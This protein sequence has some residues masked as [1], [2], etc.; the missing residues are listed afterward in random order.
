MAHH[1]SVSIRKGV[2]SIDFE[3]CLLKLAIKIHGFLRIQVPCTLSTQ[4]KSIPK[5][6]TFAELTAPN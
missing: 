2:R 4:R 3:A 6:D 1:G 5:T